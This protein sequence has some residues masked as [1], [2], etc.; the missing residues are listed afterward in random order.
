MNTKKE[1]I[2]N[3]CEVYSRQFRY[4]K[5]NPFLVWLSY[6][7]N[8]TIFVDVGTAGGLSAK[9]LAQ[10]QSN[11]VLTYDIHDKRSDFEKRISDFSNILFKTLGANDISPEWFSKVDFIYLDISPHDG[12]QEREFMDRIKPWFK[13]I[14]VLD[15]V[16][17]SIKFPG[18]Y[19]FFE[20]LDREKHKFSDFGIVPYGDWTITI[21]NEVK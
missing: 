14:L 10:N 9:A 12:I 21:I 6:R 17:N 16:N 18:L 5:L 20:E 11:L 7:F 19:R 4:E 1:L 2:V 8:N 3:I 13:G 15:D